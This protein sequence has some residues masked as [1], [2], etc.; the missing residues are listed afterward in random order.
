M[1]VNIGRDRPL[2]IMP[3]QAYE[4]P[5]PAAHAYQFPSGHLGHLSDQQASCFEQF[6]KLCQER[7]AYKPAV[8]G[9]NGGRPSHDDA[10][11]L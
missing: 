7:G 2:S 3:A 8:I 4:N 5:V 10:T 1:I 9:E 11:L 6:K